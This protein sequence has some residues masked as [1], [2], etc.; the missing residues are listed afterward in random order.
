MREESPD[1]ASERAVQA[2]IDSENLRLHGWV[3][4]E[5]DNMPAWYSSK[6]STLSSGYGCMVGNSRLEM[7]VL[8]TEH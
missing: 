8:A 4:L 2:Q 5:I 7:I 1:R 6:G 3:I